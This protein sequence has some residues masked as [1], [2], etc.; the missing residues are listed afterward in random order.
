VKDKSLHFSFAVRLSILIVGL[1]SF[2]T[3]L[4]LAANILIPLVF[5]VIIAI[6][7]S[8]VVDFLVKIRLNRIVAIFI[9]LLFSFCCLIALIGFFYFQMLRFGESWTGLVEKLMDLFHSLVNWASA[10]FSINE[11]SILIWISETKDEL[12]NSSSHGIGNTLMAVGGGLIIVFLIPVYVFLILYYKPL[13]LE[14]IYKLFGAE[15]QNKV[16]QIVTQ[17][18][19]LIQKYLV[20]LM[21]ELVII[22]LLYTIT[23]FALGI[24]Y[25][26]L[27]GVIGAL[28]NLIPYIGGIIGVALPMLVAIATKSTAWYAVYIIV[29]YYIIQLIDNNYIVPKIVASK[30]KLNA[31]I[32]IIAI[33]AGNALWGISGMFLSIPLLAVLKLIFDEIDSLK[34]WGFLLG[35]TMPKKVLVKTLLKRIKKNEI[36]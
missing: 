20:G 5:S 10:Y 15:N 23:L 19:V 14:F 11:Q 9:V 24:E 29:I 8:P 35:D 32:S 33:I 25:A 3:V 27:L 36:L 13:L 4:Y 1:L 31:F 6:V 26:I 18:K 17:T 34:P 7:L 28:L 2:V 21:I 30:V 12:I 16:E 22:A